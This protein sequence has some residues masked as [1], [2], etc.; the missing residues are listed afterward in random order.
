MKELL[1][2]VTIFSSVVGGIIGLI[3]LYYLI[4]SAVKNGIR[5]AFRQMSAINVITETEAL[6]EQK[7]SQR[8]SAVDKKYCP[9]CGTARISDLK[10]SCD[11]CGYE[12]AKG[13]A[14]KYCPDC[15]AKR[16]KFGGALD[17]VKCSQCG[18]AF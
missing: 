2:I 10:K 15:G 17:D 8:A 16:P 3:I 1:I 7:D 14:K 4:R 12:F 9:N 13:A 5:M 18:H 11:N 6:R